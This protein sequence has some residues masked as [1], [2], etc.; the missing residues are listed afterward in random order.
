[1]V[2]FLIR[3]IAYMLITVFFASLIGFAIIELPPGSYL[4]YEI[5]RLRAQGGN[6]SQDQIRALELRYGI[7]DPLPVKYYKW[8]SGFAVGDFGQ[9]FEYNKQVSELI[10]GR[11]GFTLALSLSSLLFAWLVAIPIGVYSATHKYTLPDYLITFLQFLGV[12]IPGFLLALVLMIFSSQVLGWDVGGLFS[13][14]YVDAPWSGGKLLD[15]LKHI[16]V[17]IVV[18]GASTTAG[19]TRVMRGNLL[20]VLNMQYVQTARAKGL[21]ENVVIWKHAVRNAL[22]PLVMSL[23]G[24]LPFLISGETIASLVLNLPTAGPLYTNALL[25]KDMYLAGTF[26]MFLVIL[27]VIGNFL[28]DLLLAWVDPRV[29]LE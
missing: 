19:L 3:R 17:P 13:N 20:D 7:N 10:W 16:W 29:R 8:V 23:G 11:L 4:E 21:K 26:L 27:I 28:A 14:Q 25:R 22:H 6:V 2:N 12:S 24:S 1:M 15:L 18:I 5:Q 9:S